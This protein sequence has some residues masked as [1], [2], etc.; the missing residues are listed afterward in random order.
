L[1]ITGITQTYVNV[2]DLPFAFAIVLLFF[3]A[4]FLFIPVRTGKLLLFDNRTAS[5]PHKSRVNIN[6][7][8]D[9]MLEKEKDGTDAPIPDDTAQ[10]EVPSFKWHQSL[11]HLDFWILC[12]IFFANAGSGVVIVNN[13][14]EIVYSLE[15]VKR[16]AVYK[17]EDLPHFKVIVTLVG[18][19]SVFNTLGRMTAGA[20][21]D[22][23]ASRFGTANR[24]CVLIG[25]T[26]LMSLT[27]FYFL[28]TAYIPMMYFGVVIL[29]ISYGGVYC[30]TPTLT[31]EMFGPKYFGATYGLVGVA[32]ALGSVVLSVLMA[33]KFNDYY[34]KNGEFFTV[35]KEGNTTGHCNGLDCYRYSFIVTTVYCFVSFL[36]SIWLWR[37]RVMESKEMRRRMLVSEDC[38]A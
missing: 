24:V 19:F 15:D 8:T 28:W 4:S 31:L 7:P 6:D 3:V 37:R 14:A 5:S 33:G 34:K 26:A 25:M 2:Q 38:D 30:A 27:Q 1:G 35:D 12:Y 23:V 16:N 11:R 29:G 21:S 9:A 36:L 10:N 18:L 17:P 13:F 20:V 32:P 22:M